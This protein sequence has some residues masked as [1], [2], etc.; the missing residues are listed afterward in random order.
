MTLKVVIVYASRT[1]ETKEIARCLA[2]G[3]QER[4]LQADI[5]DVG[6]VVDESQLLG[7]DGYIFG[8]SIYG[9][10]ILPEMRNFLGKLSQWDYH[11]K[12]GGAFGSY[13]WNDEVPDRI[14]EIMDTMMKMEM[15]KETL[16]LQPPLLGHK[17]QEARSYGQNIAD[18]VIEVNS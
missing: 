3:I 13:E 11:G 10:D 4:G 16:K 6:Q 15:V 7:Y 9:E 12:V 14:F 18:R 5:F 2:Q 8:S 17:E 1:G